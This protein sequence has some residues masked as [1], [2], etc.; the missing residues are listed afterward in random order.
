MKQSW[1]YIV[2][3]S[4]GSYYTGCTTNLETRISK[5]NNGSYGGYTASRRPVKLLWSQQFGDIR[6]AIEVER[7]IKKWTR[8]KKEALMKEDFETLK[9][10]ARSTRT[11]LKLKNTANPSA[12]EAHPPLAETRT[13]EKNNGTRSG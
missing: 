8:A 1:V 7:T 9:E 11:K 2:E 13:V 3:C 4:D 6:N 5:H 10:L 12:P